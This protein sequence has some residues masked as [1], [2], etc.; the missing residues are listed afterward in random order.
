VSSAAQRASTASSI[1]G[2]R[3]L[4]GTP[5]AVPVCSPVVE[6]WGYVMVLLLRF[7]DSSWCRDEDEG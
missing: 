5:K 3:G 6:T 4:A 2:N 1:C 7:V